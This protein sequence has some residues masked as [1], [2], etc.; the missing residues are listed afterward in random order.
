[1]PVSSDNS[2]SRRDEIVAGAARALADGGLVVYPTETL[3]ALGADA[4]NAGALRRLIALKVREA[5]KPIA[6]LIDGTA[7]LHGLAA[8]IPPEAEALMR[9]FWPGPLTVVLRARSSVSPLLTG[10]GNGI[11]VR[12]SSHPLATA[13]VRAL[14]RPV[15]APSANP[16]GMR[17]PAGVDEARAYFGARVDYYLDGGHLHGEPASTVVDVRAGIA[18]IREGAVPTEDLFAALKP[19]RGTVFSLHESVDKRESHPSRR[20]R[21]K[22]PPQGERKVFVEVNEGT[23]RP[24]EPP[25]LPI[26]PSS[27]PPLAAYRGTGRVSKGARWRR[28]TVFRREVKVR[29]A[30]D[31]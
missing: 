15:T 23:A 1:M 25:F 21:K 22:G 14:G 30:D 10:A 3:Y 27:G 29:E 28:A 19:G 20:S 17:P 7:M 11:G 26:I 13:L 8:E 6:V 31:C 9:R 2:D 12:L 5:G 16:A 18:V 24:E 4:C